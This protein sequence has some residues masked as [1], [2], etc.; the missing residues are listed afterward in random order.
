[1]LSRA[2]VSRETEPR[3]ANEVKPG[4]LVLVGDPLDV[5]KAH[6]NGIENV[7][8]F[9]TESISSAQLQY[10]TVLMDD[11][12][13]GVARLPRSKCLRRNAQGF[14]RSVRRTSKLSRSSEKT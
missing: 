12:A 2:S 7:V 1:M 6:E 8:S 13:R 10:L 3:E 5:L 9:L 14:K 4:E 11:A